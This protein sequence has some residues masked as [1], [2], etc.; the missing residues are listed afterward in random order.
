[1]SSGNFEEFPKKDEKIIK[2]TTYN[3]F[4]V[5]LVIT[6]GIAGFFVGTYTANLNSDQISQEEFKNE[7]ARLE[8]KMLE[9][10]LVVK[11]PSIPIKISA[12]NDPI[13]GN[14]NAPIT[15]IEFSD[16]QCPFCAK[17]NVETLPLIMNEYIKNGQVKLVFRDFPIQN[18]HPNALPASVAAECANE[19]EKFKE[20]HDI[21]FEKQ[22]DWSNQTLDNVIITF[23]Q[24][25]SDM[26]L[27]EKEFDSCL[28]NGKYIEEIQKDLDDGRAY[29]ISGTPGFFV[30]NNQIG[31]IELKG[32]QPFENFKKVIDSQLKN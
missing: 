19:Q 31:F 6:I 21:L 27:E 25:A 8:L 22:N 9:K 18:I 5:S 2:K 24:Y 20:M 14:P 30:G 32:A 16:F 17:F 3:I 7:I 13:I 15:I 26:G 1:M 29:G 23:N 11:Q 10:Q 12:D 4:I 28:K